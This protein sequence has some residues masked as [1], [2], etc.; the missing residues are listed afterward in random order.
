MK[1]HLFP[2]VVA[3]LMVA[4]L[5]QVGVVK[6]WDGAMGYYHPDRGYNPGRSDGG[7]SGLI[8]AVTNALGLRG[9]GGGGSGYNPASS[10]GE[11]YPIGQSY[12]SSYYNG[13]QAGSEQATSD[14]NGG[15]NYY[16]HCGCWGHSWTY[17][18]GFE[19]GYDTQ[20][21][22]V[23]QSQQQTT[24]QG[25]DNRVNIQD[26]PGAHVSIYNG[27]SSNQGQGAGGGGGNGP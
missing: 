11:Y 16:N 5:G 18:T 9:L 20:W 27:Q 21:N 3:V 26:S 1:H 17:R 14:Y 24:N 25:I 15:L 23:S 10:G 12:H 7:G 4:A 19:H 13:Y 2:V 6:A 22:Y 8:G